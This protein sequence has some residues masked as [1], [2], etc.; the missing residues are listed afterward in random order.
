[1]FCDGR[2]SLRREEGYMKTR[3]QSWLVV[4]SLFLA[5]V[6]LVPSR[7][8]ADDDDPPSRVARLSYTNGE[9]SFSPAGTDD[10]VAAVTNRPITTGDKLWTDRNS[11]A[12]LHIGSAAIRLGEQTGFSFLNLDDRMMQIRL[13]EG[14]IALRVRRLEQDETIEVD[15][16]NL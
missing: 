6:V 2:E 9:V 12:E 14:N 3:A 11:R 15:T 10:W 1:M 8:L 4:F 13:T 5:V 7:A 16:P